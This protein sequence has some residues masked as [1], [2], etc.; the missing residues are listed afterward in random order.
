[1]TER[2]EGVATMGSSSGGCGTDSKQLPTW[3]RKA[4]IKKL[5]ELGGLDA[6]D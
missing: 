6:R 3:L 4:V 5:A 2:A 1:M